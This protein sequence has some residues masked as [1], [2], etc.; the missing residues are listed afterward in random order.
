MNKQPTIPKRRKAKMLARRVRGGDLL[1]TFIA[2]AILIVIPLVLWQLHA[3]EPLLVAAVLA[4]VSLLLGLLWKK[5]ALRWFGPLFFYDVIRLARQGRNQGLRVLYGLLIF[6]GVWCTYTS[7]FPR[8]DLFADPFATVGSA[9]SLAGRVR[10]TTNIALIILAIQACAVIV[11]T[12]AYLASSIAEE[13]E[14]RTLEMLFTTSLLDRDI[15]LGKLLSRVLHLGMILLTSLPVLLFLQFWGGMDPSYIM[16]GFAA[17][18]LSLLSI[19]SISI[20]CSVLCRQVFTAMVASYV[21]VIPISMLGLMCAPTSPLAYVLYL[22]Q[23]LEGGFLTRFFLGISLA[24]NGAGQPDPLSTFLTYATAHGLIALFC[25]AFAIGNLRSS[26]LGEHATAPPRRRVR[27]KRRAAVESPEERPKLRS[28]GWTY[29]V[30]DWPFVWK[31]MYHQAHPFFARSSFRQTYLMIVGVLAVV[32]VVPWATYFIWRFLPV[33]KPG[34]V[35]FDAVDRLYSF[36]LNRAVRGVTIALAGIWCF[37]TG[38]RIAGSITLEREKRTLG[39]LLLL[40][41]PRWHVLVAKF[42]GNIGRYRIFGACL[43]AMWTV[44]VLVGAIHP[45]S[46]VLLVIACGIHLVFLTSLGM[47]ISLVSRSSLWAYCTMLF[48]LLAVFAGWWIVLMYAQFFFRARP[49]GRG[50]WNR[51]IEIGLNPGRTWWYFGFN[52]NELS[53]EIG[54]WLNIFTGNFAAVLAGLG[55][56]ILLTGLLWLFSWLKIRKEEPSTSNY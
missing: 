37:L 1:R 19:G 43:L 45:V 41:V 47:W 10:F 8:Y 40:P 15:I 32:L 50:W 28:I 16:A 13:K 55:V 2:A 24:G 39:S 22:E 35:F 17:C 56:M 34:V 30:T 14:H 48:A 29:P 38:M 42:L 33:E 11:L 20:L 26:A 3:P 27:P 18:F 46:A 49:G 9:A 5:Y 23:T 36:Y 12:P 7:T 25:T 52:G 51:F 31:E 54:H 6:G 53:Q 44:A 21:I 4:A